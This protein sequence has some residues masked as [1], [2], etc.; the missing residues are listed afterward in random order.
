MKYSTVSFA[1]GTLLFFAASQ[2]GNVCARAQTIRVVDTFPPTGNGT[3]NYSSGQIGKVW[4]N[5]FGGAFQSV[6]WDGAS[7]ANA[8]PNSGSL[9]ITALFNGANNQFEI[10]NGATGFNPALN[11][12]QYTNFECNVRF[13]AGSSLT[14][15]GVEASFGHLEFG[16]MTPGFGQDYFGSID[17]PATNTNWVH[18]SIPIDAM[19]DTNLLQIPALLIHIYGPF[20]SSGLAGASTLWVDNI[21][22]DGQAASTNCLIDWNDVHQRIDGFG[23]S[24]AWRTFWTTSQADMFFSTNSGTGVSLDG[25]TQ[26]P[27][28]GVGLSLLRNHINYANSTSPSAVPTTGETSIMQYAQARGARIWSAPWTPAAGFKN[29]NDIYDANH[30]TGGGINGGSYRGSGNNATNLAYASQLANYVLSMSNTYHVNIY[31][32]SMQNEPDANVTSY[33]A[34]QWTGQQFVDFVTNLSSALAAKGVGS[35]KIILPE[36][37]NWSSDSA[38]WTPT[39]NNSNGAAAVAILANHNYVPNNQVGDLTIPAQIGVPGKGLWE[40]EVAQIGGA[41]DGGM[42]NAIYWAG[43]IHHFLTDAQA[44]AWHYWWLIALNNDNEGLTDTNGIPGKRMYAL[45]Q[46]SRFVRP[47]YYRIGTKN[48]G[49]AEITAF[50]DS[51]SQNFAIVAINPN[52]TNLVQTF[53]LTNFPG[54]TFVTPWMTTSN[55]SLAAQDAVII[56]NATFSYTLPALSIVSFSGMATNITIS[57]PSLAP[58]KVS[59]LVSG[60]PGLNYT[61]LRSTDLRHWEPVMV[62]NPAAFH[63][64]MSDTN[65]FFDGSAY[66]RVVASP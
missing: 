56:S 38:L 61:L 19:S 24:S 20:Y 35:T 2:F 4:T 32:I 29:T 60:Q 23:A 55:L 58:G 18:V 50:K 1:A 11:G 33:E 52:P 49:N 7:D 45:G 26:F 8:D 41:Y 47:D 14:T 64:T 63:F 53:T 43:R 39:L 10:Y 57:T 21:Q 15:N 36:S 51:N 40:T 54:A 65:F 22:F 25:K 12:T 37:Q 62:S 66:Y 46:F 3:Y 13:A 27:F 9:K 30:A 5:W 16:V 42:A 6:A 17:V 59:M 44:N 31:G 34:C 28:N 48:G